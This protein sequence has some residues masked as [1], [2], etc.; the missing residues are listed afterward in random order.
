MHGNR[1]TQVDGDDHLTVNGTR[2]DNIGQAQL[3]EA[4][5][6]IHHKAGMKVVIEAGA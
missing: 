2:H 3:V 5:Q 6:E 1:Y 4:G